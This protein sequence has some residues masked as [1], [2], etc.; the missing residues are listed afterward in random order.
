MSSLPEA[1][2]MSSRY[3]SMYTE[4]DSFAAVLSMYEPS[5]R[6]VQIDGKAV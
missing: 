5:W 2:I 3:L 6:S 4:D 1:M